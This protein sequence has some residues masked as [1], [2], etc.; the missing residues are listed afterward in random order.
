M[1]A[2]EE[3]RRGPMIDRSIAG[4]MSVPSGMSILTGTRS[5]S[6]SISLRCSSRMA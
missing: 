3:P 1:K 2:T 5:I 6:A 4:T